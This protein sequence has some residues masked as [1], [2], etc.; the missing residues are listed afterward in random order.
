MKAEQ[1]NTSRDPKL[2]TA[3][4]RD[5]KHGTLKIHIIEKIDYTAREGEGSDPLYLPIKISIPEHSSQNRRE[6][7]QYLRDHYGARGWLDTAIDAI[8]RHFEAEAED[9][10]NDEGN[11][12]A[13]F[14]EAASAGLFEASGLL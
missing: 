8:K 4:W 11:E 5:P 2:S 12:P 14:A 1:Q 7:L 9:E 3:V 6:A 13:T 10:G